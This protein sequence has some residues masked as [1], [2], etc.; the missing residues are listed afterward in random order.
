MCPLISTAK[1]LVKGFLKADTT[2]T[3]GTLFIREGVTVY[4]TN[5]GV[6]ETLSFVSYNSG[7][8]SSIIFDYAYR[9]SLDG[10][11]YP[12][13]ARKWRAAFEQRSEAPRFGLEENEIEG[14]LVA[15]GF[16]HVKS[17]S[18]ESLENV[19]FRSKGIARKVT[20]LGAIV[21]ADVVSSKRPSHTGV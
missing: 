11:L 10:T 5:S 13:D 16:S 15:R 6:D 8:G 14:Y 21:H 18:M 17:V 4:L 20:R 1:S 7:D 9:S 3:C 2:K 12:E 19:Y